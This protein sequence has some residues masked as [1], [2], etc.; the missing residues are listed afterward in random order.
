MDFKTS[1]LYGISSLEE[2]QIILDS[3]LDEYKSVNEIFWNR[4]RCRIINNGKRLIETPD[5]N[6]K[7][8][9][10]R[11]YNLLNTLD[12][13]QYI[14]SCKGRSNISNASVHRT[15]ISTIIKLD[16]FKFF[17]STSR[18]KVYKF[19]KNDMNMPGDV[20]NIMTNITTITVSQK[21]KAYKFLTEHDIR[22]CS[23]LPTGSPTSSILSFLVNEKMYREIY[24]VVEQY[25]GNL[26]IY[27]DD[28]TIS[29]IKEASIVNNQIRSILFS[30]GYRAS[31]SKS[32][33]ETNKDKT[34]ITGVII[35]KDG[36]LLVPNKTNKKIK[37]VKTSEE[38]IER[39]ESIIKGI[40]LY[41][42]QVN[43][44]NR[45]IEGK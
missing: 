21:S 35:R 16:I 15:H 9:Q 41:Q 38:S 11:I 32:H 10:K 29:G 8:L 31:N 13:P 3:N 17:P 37:D 26:S 12:I 44:A 43:T 14:H 25:G 24:E 19:W 5:D 18:D 40:K 22:T 20:A 7:K 23:H 6:L 4:Y 28:I 45:M 1:S 30:Y 42:K 34:N 39:K 2:L 27:A 33:I 36:K